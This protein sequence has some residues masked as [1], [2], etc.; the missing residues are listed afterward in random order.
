LIPNILTKTIITLSLIGS[1]GCSTITKAVYIKPELPYI[2]NKPDYYG[3]IFYNLENQYCFNEENAKNLLKNRELDKD[4]M[5]ELRKIL[6][7]LK[8]K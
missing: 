2:P 3:V 6:E 5:E 4:Y 7:E 8:S 1:I